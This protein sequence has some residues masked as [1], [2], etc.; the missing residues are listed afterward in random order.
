MAAS[1]MMRLANGGLASMVANYLNQPGF[2]SWGNET[3]RIFGTAGFVEAVDGG[4]RTRLVVGKE[5]RGEL[6]LSAR[7]RDYF[8][9]VVDKVLDGTPMPLTLE[10]E[11]HPARMIIRAKASAMAGGA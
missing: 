4:A 11:L 2:G 6:D 8:D 3:L 5:D 7:G 9:F 1:Y 10:E